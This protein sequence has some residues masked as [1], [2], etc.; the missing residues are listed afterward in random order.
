MKR[1]NALQCTVCDKVFKNRYAVSDH[2]KLSPRCRLRRVQLSPGSKRQHVAELKRQSYL[3]RKLRVQAGT[4]KQPTTR[5][6]LS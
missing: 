2:R 3:T 6:S 1:A 5:W 4:R